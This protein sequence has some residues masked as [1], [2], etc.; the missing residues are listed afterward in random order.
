ML[1]APMMPIFMTALPEM[2][3]GRALVVWRQPPYQLRYSAK[4]EPVMPGPRL[5]GWGWG[6]GRLSGVRGTRS[7]APV[8]AAA[9][10]AIRPAAVSVT[11]SGRTSG[12]PRSA[13]QVSRARTAAYVAEADQYEA[14]PCPG[15]GEAGEAWR[16]RHQRH[17]QERQ[18]LQG[19]RHAEEV[20]YP[21][22]A[23]GLVDQPVSGI[24]GPLSA[25]PTLCAPTTGDSLCRWPGAGWAH[26]EADRRADQ[27]DDDSGAHRPGRGPVR[28]PGAQQQDGDHD[29]A[30]P[31]DDDGD[32]HRVEQCRVERFLARVVEVVCACPGSP[33]R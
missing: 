8:P 27:G 5:S 9:A 30:E 31:E 1:P 15:V 7:A 6:W 23:A 25:T 26:Q 3:G 20:R 18:Q 13:C 19:V 16:E 10:R 22:V 11:A 29:G 2:C 12:W 32:G 4:E 17:D 24:A 21:Q 14:E 28:E 33:G